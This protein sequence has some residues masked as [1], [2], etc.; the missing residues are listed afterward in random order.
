MN[1]KDIVKIL[2]EFK[3][4]SSTKWMHKYATG[5]LNWY[6]NLV[7]KEIMNKMYAQCKD[8][9]R[10]RRAEDEWNEIMQEYKIKEDK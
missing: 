1:E 10:L 8:C 7:A 6:R 4:C 9:E 3:V 5:D 2:D